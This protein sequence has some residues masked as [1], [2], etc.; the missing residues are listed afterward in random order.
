MKKPELLC[1]A[2]GM[3][4]LRAA[5]RGGAD[6]VYF[7]GTEFN[8]RMNAKNFTREN[9][10][11]AIRYCHEKGVRVYLTLNTLMTDRTIPKVLDFAAFL[12]SEGADALILADLGLAAVIRECFPDFELHASTQMSG[13]NSAHAAFLKKRGFSRM[14][15]AR[16]ISEKNLFALCE[17]SPVEIEMFVHGAICASHSGQCLMSSMIGERSGN[18]GLCA[19]PCRL[20]YNGSYPLSFKDLCLA[21]HVTSI[22][23]AGVSSL[24]IEGRMK[25]ADYVYTTARIWRRLLDE[26]RNATPQEMKELA[27]VFSRSGFT[28]GYF[29]HKLSQD[30]LGVRTEK[31]KRETEKQRVPLRENPRHL[32]KIVQKR[33][34]LPFAVPS[35]PEKK[36]QKS[37]R[38]ARFYR[39]EAIPETDFFQEIYL[40][41]EV[42]RP[43]LANGAMLPPVIFDGETKRIRAQLESAVAAGLK[44]VL[45]GNA[46]HFPLV[47]GLPVTLHGDF[48]LNVTNSFT[49][50]EYDFLDELILSPE[51]NLSQMRDLR[52]KKSAIV[53][54]RIP[55]MLLERRLSVNQIKD[56][57]GVVFPVIGEGGR[58][59]VINSVPFYMAD[60]QKELKEKA[61]SAQHFIFTTETKKEVLNVIRAYREGAPSSSP[62]RR[63]K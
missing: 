17:K 21:S 32:P 33:K 36:H 50:K 16:E 22:L 44:H 55:L 6:A 53:Y 14:V 39:P 61:P 57:R 18:Q 13:H 20:P 27:G 2:G 43:E 48:R 51:L 63:I 35:L 8:A 34:V 46:G 60:R 1:P 7:G 45:I 10:T 5:I 25:S 52:A 37:S 12:Y 49:A 24:K 23:Q 19:Q 42:Y 31:D 4:T 56:R 38:S 59:L 3:D 58:D 9:L 26:E 41:L 54:G 15:C 28:D 11:E 47:E 29:T 30:M 62:M 40:P